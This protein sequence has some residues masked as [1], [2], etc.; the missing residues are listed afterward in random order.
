MLSQSPGPSGHDALPDV[1]HQPCSEGAVA[2]PGGSITDPLL[3]EEF[4]RAHEWLRDRLVPNDIYA[5]LSVANAP[6][7]FHWSIFLCES[8]GFGHK[9]HAA[10]DGVPDGQWRYECAP[11]SAWNDSRVVAFFPMGEMPQGLD[12]T[13]LNEYLQTIPME[14]PSIDRLCEPRF[15]CRVWFKAA[16]RL[17]NDVEMFVRCSDVDGLEM[18]LA[19]RATA[20]QFS[21]GIKLLVQ[22]CARPWP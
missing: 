16:V 8:N 6:G 14:V 18:Q 13:H 7:K 21:D 11:W 22:S 17:L 9:F 15:T 10:T 20:A 5:A 19:N 4:L 12:H 1:T 2:P 3:E